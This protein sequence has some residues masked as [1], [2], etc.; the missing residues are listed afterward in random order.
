MRFPTKRRALRQAFFHAT[1]RNYSPSACSGAG[2]EITIKNL[3]ELIA[4]LTGFE[5]ALVWDTTK[6]DGQPCRCL[7]TS[8]A[9]RLLGF[10]ASTP[11]E[12]GLTRTIEWSRNQ[13]AAAVT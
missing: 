3:A 10:K 11:F 9:E 13:R 2:F 12:E 4:R 6:P 7:D 5:G 1:P 8:R